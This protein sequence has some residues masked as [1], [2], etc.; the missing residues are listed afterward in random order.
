MSHVSFD[1]L[2]DRGAIA[3]ARRTEA[4]PQLAPT[5]FDRLGMTMAATAIGLVLGFTATMALGRID[6]LATAAAS[7]PLYLIALH[8]A[9]RTIVDARQRKAWFTFSL[10]M[11]LCAALAA[12][13]LALFIASPGSPAFWFGAP[14]TLAAL[15]LLIVLSPMN[16]A[17]IARAGVLALLVA[18]LAVHQA[19]LFI[20]GA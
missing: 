5:W 11:L 1:D 20:M 2:A 7:G 16:S 10:G 13:P 9:G 4:V 14:V 8:L 19:T 6:P 17:A 3:L 15:L 18:A 12:W